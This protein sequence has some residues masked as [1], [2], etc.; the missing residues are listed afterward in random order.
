[1]LIVLLL[2][3]F[4]LLITLSRFIL[5]FF[6]AEL[7]ISEE[8]GLLSCLLFVSL[9]VLTENPSKNGQHSLKYLDLK[10]RISPMAA[11]PM[12]QVVLRR[13]RQ[14]KQ[15]FDSRIHE[16]LAANGTSG[17]QPVDL[18]GPP[19]VALPTHLTPNRGSLRHSAVFCFWFK[20]WV[21]SLW[22]WWRCS[23]SCWR[24]SQWS[25]VERTT[26]RHCRAAHY[27]VFGET[28]WLKVFEMTSTH[29]KKNWQAYFLIFFKCKCYTFVFETETYSLW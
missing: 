20:S 13:R 6:Q 4:N 1:M 14:V 9:H 29:K 12:V 27:E 26:T 7:L 11:T 8:I 15:K 17:S 5:I 22:W 16:S 18:L 23:F 19:P 2:P 25:P 10:I 3:P 21:S 28:S 24:S